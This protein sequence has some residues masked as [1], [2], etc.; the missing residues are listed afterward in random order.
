LA[1]RTTRRPNFLADIILLSKGCAYPRYAYVQQGQLMRKVVRP[2]TPPEFLSSPAVNEAKKKILGYLR[3]DPDARSQRRDNI[4]E[5]LFFDSSLIG[6]LRHLF[7]DKCAFCESDARGDGRLVHLR[8][9][10]FVYDGRKVNRDY[11]LWLAFEW[12]NLFYACTHCAKAKGEH[13]PVLGIR[14]PYLASFED[15][16]TYERPLLIDPTSDEPSKDLEFL[17]N[18]LVIGKTNRGTTSI[19]LLKL[20]R[21]ELVNARRHRI[22]TLCD[23]LMFS[24]DPLSLARLLTPDSEHVGTLHSIVQKIAKKWTRSP[25]RI[26]GTGASLTER[27]MKAFISSSIEQRMQLPGILDNVRTHA[28]EVLMGAHKS[29]TLDEEL[30]EAY[31]PKLKEG[32]ISLIQISNFK[33][34]EN[35][36][37]TMQPGRRE[38]NSWPSLMILGENSTGK[39]SILCAIALALIGRKEAAKLRRY[40]PALVHSVDTNHHD[41]S[42]NRPVAVNIGFHYSDHVA[43][44]GYEP[45]GRRI[46]GTEIPSTV[47]IGYGPRRFFDHRKQDLPSG[48]AARVR[49]LFNPLATIPYPGVWLAQQTGPTFDTIAAALRIVLALDDKDEL[50]RHGDDLAVRANGRTTTIHSLSEGYR[51]VFVMTVDIIRELLNHWDDLELAQ[52]VVLIDEIETHLHPRWKMQVMTSLR[53]V[54]PRVQFIVTTHDP[55]CLR[56]MDDAEVIVLRRDANSF[57]RPVENLPSIKTMTA[58]QLFTSDYFGLSSTTDPST[59]IEFAR[60]AG[61]VVRRSEQGD[62]KVTP[63][64]E[65]TD[66]IDRL[67]IGDSVSEQVVQEALMKYLEQRELNKGDVPPHLREEAVNAVLQALTEGRS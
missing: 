49:T 44:F 65:T 56:G 15:A 28:H 51:S 17:F 60:L 7:Q 30:V 42:D 54:F 4:N 20:N 31:R 48:A 32:E 63:A 21:L 8:P 64:K 40:V 19:E 46:S 36:S 3:L 14:A 12:R 29:G 61:D 22:Q 10:R 18:G 9:M 43:S 37:L 38:S 26:G 33:A 34:L 55:L 59:A 27:F 67:V 52:A 57:I 24:S 35:L 45:E 13:F 5:K 66:L 50:I 23:T 1:R 41:Q 47:V 62:I 2:I 58:E 25:L 39:S 11:Y 16:Q 6:S 53:R